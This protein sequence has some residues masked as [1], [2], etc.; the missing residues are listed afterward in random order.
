VI[1][2]DALVWGGP[3]MPE[4]PPGNAFKIPL[5][6]RAVVR[7]LEMA[8]AGELTNTGEDAFRLLETAR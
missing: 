7:A 1:V 8:A 4:S 2:R 6:R 3:G 5:A